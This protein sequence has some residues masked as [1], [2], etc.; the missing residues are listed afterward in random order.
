L[1]ATG[2]LPKTSSALV[3]PLPAAVDDA[4]L[5]AT[6]STVATEDTL[7]GSPPTILSHGA[8]PVDGGT[9]SEAVISS[10]APSRIPMVESELQD[11][12]VFSGGVGL[13]MVESELQNILPLESSSS[14][15]HL[16]SPNL[17]VYSRKRNQKLQLIDGTDENGI[18]GAAAD[19]IISPAS[20]T[21]FAADETDHVGQGPV[22]CGDVADGLVSPNLSLVEPTA[23]VADILMSPAGV[24]H[25]LISSH[26]GK[27]EASQSMQREEFIKS[28]TRQ[29]S[30]LLPAP[31]VILKKKD[32]ILPPRSVPRRSCRV[33]GVG[34]EFNASDLD[35]R[36]TKKIMKA[37]GIIADNV[38]IDQRAQEEYADLFK[39]S[40]SDTHV[41]ALAA[42]F[43]WQLPDH[44]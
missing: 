19:A 31:P 36:A 39:T 8:I 20:A 10:D 43:G 28:V 32:N 33:A 42:L 35:R 37:V 14:R 17:L 34:V 38:G 29:P 2:F 5:E 25:S 23:A 13:P 4:F 22:F 26:S 40:L 12:N 3:S 11:V 1:T 9:C 15:K 41:K 30:K 18:V 44:L 6:S 16:M 27:Q 24:V 21:G 7:A